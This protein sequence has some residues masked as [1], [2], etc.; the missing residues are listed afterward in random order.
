ME[1]TAR[2]GLEFN[3]FLKNSREILY[4]GREYSEAKDPSGLPRRNERLRPSH[5]T[6]RK[7]Q[8]YCHQELVFSTESFSLQGRLYLSLYPDG[9]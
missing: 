6:A 2:Y 4:K 3:P 7:G 5:R 8:D 1:L 9:E